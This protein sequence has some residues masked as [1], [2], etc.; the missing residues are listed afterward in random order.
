VSCDEFS[1]ISREIVSGLLVART[2]RGPGLGTDTAL[3][4]KINTEESDRQSEKTSFILL[5]LMTVK[6]TEIL[7]GRGG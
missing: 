6:F 7:R 1:L 4:G 3:S 5:V 2:V